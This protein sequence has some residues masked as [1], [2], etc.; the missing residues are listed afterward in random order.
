MDMLRVL[1]IFMVWW[2]II[3]CLMK[4]LHFIFSKELPTPD[5]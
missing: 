2:L 5:K 1:V 4:A 3:A